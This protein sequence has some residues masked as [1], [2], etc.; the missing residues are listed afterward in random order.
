MAPAGTREEFIDGREFTVALLAK[1]HNE[2]T[3]LPIVEILFENFPEGSPHILSYEAKWLSESPEYRGTSSKCP[4]DLDSEL[5][6]KIRSAALD[7]ARVV[8]LKD[9]GRI[10]VRV[11]RDDN[12]VFVLDVNAN[13]DFG[14]DSDFVLAAK[15]S[16]RTYA[17]VVCEVL[18]CAIDRYDVM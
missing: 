5:E 17:Q 14:A 1:S 2:F 9:Y 13:P 12:A 18:Q 4:A 6:E 15:A 16:G 11:R 8:D 3:T 10:D 7:A